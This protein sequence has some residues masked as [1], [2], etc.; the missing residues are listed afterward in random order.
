M[1]LVQLVENSFRAISNFC[2]Q[3]MDIALIRPQDR[4]IAALTQGSTIGVFKKKTGIMV[5]ISR[6]SFTFPN[7]LNCRQ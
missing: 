7:H 1:G 2:V 6:E 3:I 4:Y 5:N